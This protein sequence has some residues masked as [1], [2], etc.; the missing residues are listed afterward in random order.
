MR[1][2]PMSRSV[3]YTSDGQRRMTYPSYFGCAAGL[4]ASALDMAEFSLAL[5]RD[6]FF[7]QQTKELM[8][9]PM[10]SNSGDLSDSAP[11]TFSSTENVCL[12]Y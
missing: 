2:S 8:F 6:M 5:D 1:T 11:V 12:I 9:T 7:S 10:L 3:P 4:V